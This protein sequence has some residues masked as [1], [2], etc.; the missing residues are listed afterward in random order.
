MSKELVDV[1]TA[2]ERC[3]WVSAP[4]SHVRPGRCWAVH[5]GDTAIVETVAELCDGFCTWNL[6][7]VATSF[8]TLQCW[9]CGSELRLLEARIDANNYALILIGMRLKLDRS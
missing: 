3:L 4:F 6:Q 7:K 9:S 8:K 1:I 2:V 5:V